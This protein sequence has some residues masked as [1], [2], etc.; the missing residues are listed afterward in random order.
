MFITGLKH[1]AKKMNS[2]PSY[3]SSVA[4]SLHIVQIYFPFSLRLFTYKLHSLFTLFLLKPV[5]RIVLHARIPRLSTIFR[6][7]SPCSTSIGM[8]KHT[9]FCCG[10][11]THRK[12]DYSVLF[13]FLHISYIYTYVTIRSLMQSLSCKYSRQRFLLTLSQTFHLSFSN[14][15]KTLQ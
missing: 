2:A 9:F 10:S 15:I 5:V 3:P 11:L 1:I 8:F 14:N 7:S 4:A 13:L 6:A 12:Q